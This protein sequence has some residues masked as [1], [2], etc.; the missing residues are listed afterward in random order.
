MT[1][2]TQIASTQAEFQRVQELQR[3]RMQEEKEAAAAAAA[4]AAAEAEEG[5]WRGV[6]AD[7]EK[8][9]FVDDEEEEEGAAPAGLSAPQVGRCGW[10]GGCIIH[11]NISR[12]ANWIDRWASFVFAF[13]YTTTSRSSPW[14]IWSSNV[15]HTQPSSSRGRNR[16][17]GRGMD[18]DRRCCR[19]LTWRASSSR[20]SKGA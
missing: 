2:K 8:L 6:E 19:W 13:A 10:V 15:P 1:T 9:T 4:A 3:R 11:W 5:D 16:D 18:M 12:P 17:R 7:I 14:R 20:G